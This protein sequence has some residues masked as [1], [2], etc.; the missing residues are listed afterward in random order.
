LFADVKVS[1]KQ[2]SEGDQLDDQL[3]FAVAEYNAGQRGEAAAI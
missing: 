2:L 3:A 1:I